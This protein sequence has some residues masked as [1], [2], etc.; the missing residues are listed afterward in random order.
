MSLESSCERSLRDALSYRLTQSLTYVDDQQDAA[1]RI[2]Q[3]NQRKGVVSVWQLEML[4]Y[5]SIRAFA[6]RVETE[7]DRLDIAVLNAG[8]SKMSFDT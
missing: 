3:R 1:Q 8:V 4:D 6:H 7:L 5:T 2:M